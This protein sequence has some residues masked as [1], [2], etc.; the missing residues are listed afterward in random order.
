M[1]SG[2]HNL[3]GS[4]Q[5]NPATGFRALASFV[6]HCQSKA[7]ITKKFFIE[8]RRRAHHVR[9]IQH[10]FD[11]LLFKQ[12]RVGLELPGLATHVLLRTRSWFRSC[13]TP[14]FAKQNF[15]L[16]EHVAHDFHRF[17]LSYLCVECKIA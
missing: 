12:S 16:T 11:S 7:T 9:L 6:N 4:Q 8:R 2:Q 17:V 14:G 15:G 1:I 13:K 5:G 3:I 10:R